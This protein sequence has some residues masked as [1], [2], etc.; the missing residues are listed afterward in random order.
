MQNVETIQAR[1]VELEQEIAAFE[2]W[3]RDWNAGLDTA[4]D[5]RVC[6]GQRTRR[7]KGSWRARYGNFSEGLRRRGSYSRAG[8]QKRSRKK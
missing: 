3:Q 2:L 8:G 5:R 4:A 7:L 6:H 1:R